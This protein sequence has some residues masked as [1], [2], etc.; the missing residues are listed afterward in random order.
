MVQ[1]FVRDGQLDECDLSFRDLHLLEE[2][3]A[4]MVVSIYHARIEYPAAMAETAKAGVA[5]DTGGGH[6]GTLD[7]VAQGILAPVR[8]PAPSVAS[9]VPVSSDDRWGPASL[10]SGVD[11]EGL[12][13]LLQEGARTL[14]LPNETVTVVTLT[15]DEQL[16]DYNRRYRGLDETTD[17]L[18][19]AAQEQPL[20]QRFQAPG[21]RTLAGDIVIALPQARRQARDAGRDERR[22]T[23]TRGARISPPSRVRPRRAGRGGDHDSAHEADPGLLSMTPRSDAEFEAE[24]IGSPSRARRVDLRRT[25]YSFRHAGRGFAWAFSSQANLRVH[26][27]AAVVVW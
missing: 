14:D 3:M 24:R 21:H 2:A 8:D 22:G 15:G 16:R 6:D 7:A 26:F 9:L 1:G 25:L 23:A 17:V 11:L 13:T 10:A 27:L 5:V 12:E 4:N 19:F 20:D 18:A